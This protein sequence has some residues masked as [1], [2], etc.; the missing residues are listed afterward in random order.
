MNGRSTGTTSRCSP[1][2]VLRTERRADHTGMQRVGGH[3]RCRQSPRQ[4]VGEQ[5]VGELG[6]VVGARTRVGPFA[7]EV[8]E[9]DPA[10]GLRVGGDGDHPAGALSEPVEQQVGQQER[11]EVVEREGALEAVGGDV[12]GVPVPADVVDQHVDPG[13][14]CEHLL[15]ASRRT[16]AWEDMSATKTS[17]CAPWPRGSRARCPRRVAVPAGDRDPGAEPARPIAVALPMPPVA[18]VTTTVLPVIGAV[19]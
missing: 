6:L 3:P 17:T 9:V 11:G 15:R 14:P 12:P 5:H 19:L 10:H 4:L 2:G 7:L 13:R 1:A 8:V 18:P 16:S